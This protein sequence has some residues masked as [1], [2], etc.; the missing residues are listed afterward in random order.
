MS[1]LDLDAI[2]RSA[3]RGDPQLPATVVALC[4]EVKKAQADVSRYLKMALDYEVRQ[5]HADVD[6][7]LLRE[8]VEWFLAESDWRFFHFASTPPPAAIDASDRHHPKLAIESAG[9][10]FVQVLSS[11]R[12]YFAAVDRRD[13]IVAAEQT[14]RAAVEQVT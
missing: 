11:A 8:A 13:G 2:R 6:A 1:E 5:I 7:M 3:A 14:L 12:A 4:D 10:A 9:T